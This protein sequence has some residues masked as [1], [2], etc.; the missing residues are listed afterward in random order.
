MLNQTYPEVVAV[1]LCIKYVTKFCIK[2]QWLK[3]LHNQYLKDQILPVQ[4]NGTLKEQNSVN[5]QTIGIKVLGLI[6][7][8][9]K[10]KNFKWQLKLLSI[11]RHLKG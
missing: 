7:C 6:T 1:I 11:A 10:I 9:V 4:Q 8:R 2:G 5:F 3:W